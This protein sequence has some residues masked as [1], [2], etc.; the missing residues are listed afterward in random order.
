M[1]WPCT[2]RLLTLTE[3]FRTLLHQLMTAEIR[4]HDIDLPGFNELADVTP[5]GTIQ[6][7]T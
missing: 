1:K 5:Q 2:K 6:G 7:S 3:L 4:V